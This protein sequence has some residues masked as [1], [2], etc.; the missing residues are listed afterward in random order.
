MFR[1][2][3]M[4]WYLGAVMIFLL[5]FVWF[6]NKPDTPL[7]EKIAGLVVVVVLWGILMLLF[8]A[9]WKLVTR[10]TGGRFRGSIGQHI[11]E[12]GEDT[13]AESN[14]QGRQEVRVSGL[15]RVVETDLHFFVITNSGTGYVIPKKDLQSFDALHA[16]QKRVLDRA[17]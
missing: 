17:A 5:V 6:S 13:F 15:R 9:F 8:F 1:Y 4:H 14:A 16:L 7:A 11:F 2:R 10:L 3:K 12:V